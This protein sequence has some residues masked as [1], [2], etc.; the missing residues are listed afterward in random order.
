MQD[1]G[2]DLMVKAAWYYHV[3]G[4]T[5]ANIAERLNLTR[6]RVNEMLS[7]AHDSGLVSVHFNSPLSLCAEL[8][9]RLCN[10][11]GLKA[12]VVVPTP[13]D[14]ALVHK[15]LGRAT[16]DFLTQLIHARKPRSIGLGWG[17]TLRETI[18]AARPQKF[19]DLEVY[20][21]MGGLTHGT[22]INTFEIVRSFA[23]R[24]GAS[25]N[26]L[27]APIY[28]DSADARRA[29]VAQNSFR[30]ALEA[31]RN[32][33]VGLVSVGD[34][35][36]KSLQ[37]RYG[38]P[39]GVDPDELVR[40]GAVGDLIGRY[41][42]SDGRQIDHPLN[43]QVMSP[44]IEEFRQIPNRILASGGRHKHAIMRAVVAAGHVNVAITDADCAAQ[45]LK[46]R[47]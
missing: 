46:D 13:S 6:R 38:L 24:F 19:E 4:M 25:G 21:I 15:V 17:S 11:F 47:P 33:D 36:D 26:Y 14:P 39:E 7:Q 20:S 44:E 1:E 41:L 29:I 9:S 28:M 23:E 45:L 27:V 16:A 42:D 31:I 32:A 5:Q 3:E 8:E 37:V 18:M 43:H 12:A 2:E 22:E 10:R 34:V 35:S 30:N 40:A